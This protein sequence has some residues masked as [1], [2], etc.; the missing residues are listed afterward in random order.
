M[1]IDILSAG[2]WSKASHF[3]LYAVILSLVISISLFQI[4]AALFM[5]CAILEALLSRRTPVKRGTFVLLMVLFFALTALSLLKTQYPEAS[6]RGLFR[7]FRALLLCVCVVH[8]LRDEAAFKKA[9]YWLLMVGSVVAADAL[10]QGATGFE[11]FRQR[12]MTPYIGTLKRLT[13]PFHHANDFSA[14]LSFIVLVYIGFVTSASRD[15]S[16]RTRV[17]LGAALLAL[18]VCL[19]GTYARGAWLAVMAAFV[20]LVLFKRSRVLIAVLALAV[21]WAVLFA[22]ATV[23]DRWQT[24]WKSNDGTVVERR[25]LWGESVRMVRQSPWVGLGINTYARNEPLFKAEGSKTDKQYAHNGYLQIAAETGLLG[26]GGF[27]AFL[28]YFIFSTLRAF[29]RKSVLFVKS[30]GTALVFGAVSLLLHATTDTDLQ[31]VLLVNTLWTAI[32]LAWAAKLL[33]EK[34]NP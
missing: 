3:F 25:E 8:T 22:P 20:F 14:Y 17:L 28:G 30:A 15:V 23:K 33:D 24:L 10:A 11:L 26:L 34:A 1:R 31:S 16:K 7:N 27:L 4:S 21:G 29:G 18:L 13:G 32:G 2:F 6:L 5:G 9:F 19:A 12:E